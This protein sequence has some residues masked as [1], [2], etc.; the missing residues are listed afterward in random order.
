MRK[1]LIAISLIAVALT[2][3]PSMSNAQNATEGA[4]AGAGVGAA[5]GLVVGGPVGAAVGAG[6][7]GT[8]GASAGDSNR[9]PANT[10][11]VV[12]PAQST[13]TVDAYGNR[14]CV[15]H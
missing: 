6:V 10:T 12:D 3:L 15:R 11:V 5:T 7:G 9:A 14:T 4:A 2:T 1:H 13:C 8:V